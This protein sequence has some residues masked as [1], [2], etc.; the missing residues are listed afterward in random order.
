MS[1]NQQH[2]KNIIALYCIIFYALMIFKWWGGLFLYQLSPIIY[3]TRF[4]FFTWQLMQTGL[5]TWLM[6]H[7]GGRYL[8]DG[9][10]YSM[11]FLYW[12]THRTNQA[13]A[14]VVAIIMLVVNWVYIQCYT[15][16]PTSSIESFIGWLLFP[17]LFITISLRSFYFMLQG[18]RYFFLFLFASAGL[19]KLVQQ[20]AFNVQQMSG[21]LLYQH[22][23]FLTSS[24]NYWLTHFF[25]WIIN[26]PM[27][28]YIMYL[29]GTLLELMFITGFF[30]RKFD[31]IL[32]Y[33]FIL[34]LILDFF[35]MRIYYWEL[36]PF[37]ITLL[38]SRYKRPTVLR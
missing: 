19:W 33:A 13:R 18:L 2:R 34:F 15:L 17:L 26:H 30:T 11:P 35:L 25:Y 20:G 3:Q 22:K 16:Y 38:Y 7:E 8:M 36:S 5:H 12:L 14:T 21:V 23:E 27:V 28:G 1:I 10:F 9:L 4:D 6:H 32:L 29:L 31:R 24:P 37:I